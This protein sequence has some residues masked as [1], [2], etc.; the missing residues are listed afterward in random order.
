MEK[1]VPKNGEE[2]HGKTF[3]FFYFALMVIALGTGF[4]KPIVS[5]F[6]ADQLRTSKG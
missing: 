2:G 4:I 5:T 1:F 6:G 3:G